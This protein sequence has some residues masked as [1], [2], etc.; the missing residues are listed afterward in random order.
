MRNFLYGKKTYIIS[1]LMMLVALV[2]LLTGGLSMVEFLSS[3]DLVLL[4]E[5]LGLSALRAGVSKASI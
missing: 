5:G 2:E 4:L 1:G 3:P